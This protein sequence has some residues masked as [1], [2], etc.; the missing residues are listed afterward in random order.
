MPTRE[1]VPRGYAE[2]ARQRRVVADLLSSA[3]PHVYLRPP[4]HPPRL[5]LQTKPKPTGSGKALPQNSI[6][7]KATPHARHPDQSHRPEKNKN[8]F[9]SLLSIGSVPRLLLPPIDREGDRGVCGARDFAGL[10]PDRGMSCFAHRRCSD[11]ARRQDGLLVF[12]FFLS[13]PIRSI[14]NSNL[15]SSNS[16]SN[17]L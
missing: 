10:E 5:Y 7:Y 8:F 1:T 13:I 9:S 2:A 15:S 17:L 16:S 4:P 6:P 11:A 3:H 12:V 14:S